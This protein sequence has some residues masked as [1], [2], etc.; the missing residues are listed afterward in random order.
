VLKAIAER[1]PKVHK[2]LEAVRAAR[3]KDAAHKLGQPV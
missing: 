1:Y 2:L 3:H